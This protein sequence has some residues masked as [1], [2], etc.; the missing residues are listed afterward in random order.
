LVAAAPAPKVPTHQMAATRR[1]VALARLPVEQAPVRV[2]TAAV[3]RVRAALTKNRAAVPLAPMDRAAAM[4]ML[5][6]PTQVV[7]PTVR[8]RVA[9][10]ARALAA[11]VRV[12]AVL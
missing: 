6:A 12:L 8:V 11:P 9:V 4:R 7:V 5:G 3:P 2:P 1:R 10:R